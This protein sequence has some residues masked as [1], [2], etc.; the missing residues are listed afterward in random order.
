MM[1]DRTVRTGA[2][3]SGEARGGASCGGW[4]LAATLAP[5]AAVLCALV[6]DGH[7]LRWFDLP[8]F[9]RLRVNADALLLQ[10]ALMVVGAPL[11]GVAIASGWMSPLPPGLPRVSNR[12]WAVAWRLTMGATALAVTSAVLGWVVAGPQA[13][14]ALL[15]VSRTV[16]W[17]STFALGTIGAMCALYFFD[18]LDA[19]GCAL[20]LALVVTTGAIAIGPLALDLP[21]A[22]VDAALVASPLVAVASAADIDILRGDVMY[23]LSPIAHARFDYPSWETAF[24]LSIA[25]V[26]V[27]LTAMA[28]NINRMGRTQSAGRIPS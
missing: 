21:T 1:I 27:C 7:S 14:L 25:A 12:I 3:S 13:D 2:P 10:T 24:G 28:L 20:G 22:V 19:A 16:L 23:R 18:P 6:M 17:G 15:L 4:W 5:A 26:L 9:V 11:G 8:R